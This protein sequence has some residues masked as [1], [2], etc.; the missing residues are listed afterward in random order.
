MMAPCGIEIKVGQTWHKGGPVYGMSYI[1]EK[2]TV[3]PRTGAEF[4][5]FRA[6]NTVYGKSAHVCELTNKRGGFRLIKD[7]PAK[8][9]AND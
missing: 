9:A 3:H 5:L 4:V 7:V 1:V 2:L 8:E 6:N